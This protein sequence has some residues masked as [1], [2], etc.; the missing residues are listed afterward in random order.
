MK[1]HNPKGLVDPTT[2]NDFARYCSQNKKIQF[3][4]FPKYMHALVKKRH[5]IFRKTAKT[6]NFDF[7]LNGR[8]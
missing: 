8:K 6:A 3:S 2:I 4:K 5:L 7:F 1:Y